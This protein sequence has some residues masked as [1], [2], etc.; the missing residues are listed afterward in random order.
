MS[1][2]D[3]AK[4]MSASFLS[5]A[6]VASW[7]KGVSYGTFALEGDGWHFAPAERVTTDFAMVA[8]VGIN[9]VRRYAP[10][11]RGGTRRRSSW[12]GAGMYP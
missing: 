1:K 7:Q 11:P 4:L 5:T 8:E 10:P 3:L 12:T 6:G 9:M 2:V